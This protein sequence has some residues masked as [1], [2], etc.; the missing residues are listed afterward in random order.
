MSGFATCFALM[1]ATVALIAF[2]FDI[3]IF[4]IAK[5]RIEAA[6]GTAVLGN[7][8][9]MTLV[10]MLCLMFSGCFFGVRPPL[11]HS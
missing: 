1:G 6:S 3:V 11:Y 8:I 7:A 2:I 9:W 5:K 4:V 10:G